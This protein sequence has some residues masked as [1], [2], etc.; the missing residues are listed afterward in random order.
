MSITRSGAELVEQ[1]AELAEAAAPAD[2]LAEHD[3][4]VGPRR[5]ANCIA[6]SVA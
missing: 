6:S 5:I 3:H 2:V 1:P 4:P